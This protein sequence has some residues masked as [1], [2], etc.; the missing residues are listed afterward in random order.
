MK[1]RPG[2]ISAGVYCIS[3]QL[4]DLIPRN[5]PS[6][7]CLDLVPLLL[8]AGQDVRAVRFDGKW[9][10]LGAIDRYLNALLSLAHETHTAA[11]LAN[12]HRTATLSGRVHLSPDSS[13]GAHAILHDSALMPGAR[14][15][16]HSIVS[17][18]I[19]NGT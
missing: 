1:K 12:I 14:I 2:L 18:E 10:D 15:R 16:P 11:N 13:A 6:D 9:D 8:A 4:L 19:R 7:Y 17:N 3:G 5:R